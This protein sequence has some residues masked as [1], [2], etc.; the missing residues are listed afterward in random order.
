MERTC[1][2]LAGGLGTRLLPVTGGL[3]PKAMVAVL[4]RPFIDFKLRSLAAM[5]VT[6]AVLLVGERADVLEA[7]VGDGR[8][9]GLDAEFVHDG[10][11][12]KGT[13]GA[14]RAA[15][16]RLPDR[17]WVT[18]GD[19]LVVADLAIAEDHLSRLGSQALMTVLNNEDRWGR[20]NVDVEGDLVTRYERHPS[21]GTLAWIDY[22]LL[23]FRKSCF[24][25]DHTV[26]PLDLGQ[27]VGSLIERGSCAA[28]RVAERFWEVGTPEA[29]DETAAQLRSRGESFGY[30]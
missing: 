19:S 23:L 7:H 29:L 13:G 18:Y 2:V 30:P 17:F 5:G 25:D 26:D 28:M 14:I 6:R 10:A 4:G 8:A 12:L 27:V 11:V 1:V 9:F 16:D 21:A 3:I 24:V 15:L 22:G 20:S